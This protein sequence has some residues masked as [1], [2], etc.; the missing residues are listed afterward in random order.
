MRKGHDARDAANKGLH[1]SRAVT[2][3][4]TNQ[5]SLDAARM[6]QRANPY[7]PQ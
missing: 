2:A 1:D 6:I 3:I 7:P 4:G 5:S